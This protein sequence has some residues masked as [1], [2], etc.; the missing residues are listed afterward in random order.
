MPCI[1]DIHRSGPALCAL[2]LMAH[3]AKDG[4]G[5]RYIMSL[6]NRLVGA[7]HD[8]QCAGV[9]ACW[10]LAFQASGRDRFSCG[11]FSYDRLQ[12][13]HSAA[14][15]SLMPL[16]LLLASAFWPP[17][18]RSPYTRFG[19]AA[20]CSLDRAAVRHAFMSIATRPTHQW[21]APLA[22]TA[23]P[24]AADHPAPRLQA[25]QQPNAQDSG[26]AEPAAQVAGAH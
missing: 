6:T 7:F 25:G 19:S 18:G 14:G 10:L 24:A 26:Q 16:D 2:A 17:G 4:G 8:G 22:V 21:A 5:C 20:G 9:T 23:Q 11:Y 1:R 3:R 12:H 15:F 13:G